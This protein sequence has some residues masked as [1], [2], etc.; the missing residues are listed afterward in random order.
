MS[1]FDF[2]GVTSSA[3]MMD[4]IF[5]NECVMNIK[6]ATSVTCPRVTPTPQ[7][8]GAIARSGN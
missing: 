7:S 6:H 5:T 1:S 4:E 3:K 2:V 8:L